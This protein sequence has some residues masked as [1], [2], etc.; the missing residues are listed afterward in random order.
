MVFC[1]CSLAYC[2]AY[3]G[4]CSAVQETFYELSGRLVAFR[5][6]DTVFYF[7]LKDY[8]VNY[9]FQGTVYCPVCDGSSICY[10]EKF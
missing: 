3:T 8:M 10:L 6:Y 5:P 9:D 4:T 1:Q 7:A 2:H